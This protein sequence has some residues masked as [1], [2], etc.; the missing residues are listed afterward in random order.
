LPAGPNE[1]VGQIMVHNGPNGI[2][3]GQA[4]MLDAEL[5]VDW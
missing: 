3:I 5:L 1:Y 2:A 4:S